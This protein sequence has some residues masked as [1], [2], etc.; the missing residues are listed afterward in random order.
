M[1]EAMI[2]TY[3]QAA[4]RALLRALE[5]IPETIVFGEDVAKPGGV[6]GVT[7]GLRDTFGERVFDTPISESAILGGALGAALMGRRPVVEIMW[8]DFTLVALDQIVNQAANVRYVS[9]GRLSAPLTIRTQQGAVPGS[10]AQHSQ[11]LE[12]IFAHIPGLYVGMP[13]TS[14]DAYDMLLA[15]IYADDPIIIIE[16][17]AL[18]FSEKG[19]VTLGAAVQPVGGA[20]IRREGNDLTLVSWGAMSHTALTAAQRLGRDGIA[21]EVIDARWLAPFDTDTVIESVRK[22]GRL[23]IAHEA[24][25]SGGFGAEVAARIASGPAFH[26]L[27]APICRV[28]VPDCRIPAAPGLQAAL[29][30]SVQTIVDAVRETVAC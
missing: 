6:F 25:V 18:Y 29:L 11:N 12:A 27:D 17:R 26:S 14:Q 28:G 2:L 1:D 10:C 8:A 7:K 30:P 4:N 16:N 9:N 21:V 20:R 19:P 13:A 5:E 22:T 24:N 3:A 23:V 15:A